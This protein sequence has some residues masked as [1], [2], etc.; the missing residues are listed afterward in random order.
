[1]TYTSKSKKINAVIDENA[2][3]VSATDG[4]V[5]CS[6][7]VWKIYHEVWDTEAMEWVS[8]LLICVSKPIIECELSPDV[9][10]EVIRS[11]ADLR[12]W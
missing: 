11:I 10:E 12:S 6:G 2:R 7:L 4:L 1:M 3:L 9:A 5:G 8:K